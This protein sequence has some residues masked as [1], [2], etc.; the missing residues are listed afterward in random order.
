VDHAEP[1][2]APFF[3]LYNL[4]GMK[5][6][7]SI[8]VRRILSALLALIWFP[9]AV[10]VDYLAGK[11]VS[12]QPFTW[13]Y[14][15]LRQL[16][17]AD[18][19]AP[20]QCD[21]IAAYV[22]TE[23]ADLEIRLDTLT[24]QGPAD[25]DLYLAFDLQNGGNRT[26]PVR[27]VS[28]LA[29]DYLLIAR[30]HQTP[31]VQEASGATAPLIPQIFRDPQ[32]DTWIIRLNRYLLPGPR[33][34]VTF[35]AWST[36]PDHK[37]IADT[38][39]PFEFSAVPPPPAS[40]LLV[41]WDTLPAASP[42]Q[43]L[44]RWD[45]AHTGPYGQRH[46]LRHLIEAASQ[47]RVPIVLA[48]LMTPSSLAGLDAVGGLKIVQQAQRQGWLILP[49]P[50]MGMPEITP[51]SQAFSQTTRANFGFFDSSV[52]FGAFPTEALS[53]GR[54][55][56][57][58]LADSSL[59]LQFNGARLLPLPNGFLQ[60]DSFLPQIESS[61][62]LSLP[63]KRTLIRT[64]LSP[65]PTDLVVLGE[66]LPTSPWADRRFAFAVMKY[67]A[68]HPWIHVLDEADLW[69][70]PARPLDSKALHTCKDVWCTQADWVSLTP[71]EAHWIS[72]FNTT[73]TTLRETPATLQ[74]SA[75]R[76]QLTQT[77]AMLSHPTPDL[78]LQKLRAEYRGELG[79]L[80]QALK[81][82]SQ[83]VSTHTCEVD[84]DKD[85][86]PECI[87][88]SATALAILN[89]QG[90]RLVHLSLMQPEGPLQIIAPS[91]QLT[92][93]LSDP[94]T[95]KQENGI[96][97]DP[98]VVPGG[99][100]HP[101]D[102]AVYQVMNLESTCITLYSPT[103]GL[104]KRYCLHPNGLTVAVRGN[105]PTP[106]LLLP[107]VLVTSERFSPGWAQRYF[108]SPI[109][110][111]HAVWAVFGRGFVDIRANQEFEITSFTESLPLLAQPEDPNRDYPAGHYIPFP[112][113]LL[114]FPDPTSLLLEI[115]L[116]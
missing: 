92:I 35:Q 27:A 99:V 101:Q 15:D 1:Q 28:P 81:W 58:R 53:P 48:D 91:A 38:I 98:T 90:G 103:T 108:L 72:L 29:W 7:Q 50:A 66:S 9:L 64:A 95:W 57:S 4:C 96:W 8:T 32:Q 107:L 45:G 34:Q 40:L 52:R 36:L 55:Y 6:T 13:R 17:S 79:Y 71:T 69:M 25:C 86:M 113:A 19:G 46:G 44:R 104:E 37:D 63:V 68:N 59:I 73:T 84:L 80:Q 33:H 56:F 23:R 47:Y 109:S 62:R 51:W 10:G 102:T 30:A 16:D 60:G 49:T 61:G 111:T 115:T 5:V 54:A 31:L 94:A 74:T 67:L 78:A 83:P 89:L 14:D 42:A 112:M 70:H 77:A 93:G 26:L 106:S 105:S 100:V 39:G 43:V 75:F 3:V 22:R 76:I 88:I 12:A 82:A 116:N 97:A 24:S 11:P 110:K 65:D 2:G 85:G 87:L 20:P 114:T 18:E 21:F 41:F